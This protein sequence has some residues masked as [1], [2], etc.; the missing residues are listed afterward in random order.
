MRKLIYLLLLTFITISTTKAQR[1][2]DLKTTLITPANATH[3]A[4]GQMFNIRI[5]IKNLSA[6]AIEQNDSIAVY[7]LHDNDTIPVL[8]GGNSSQYEAY[9][10]NL[11]KQ[12]DSVIV[13]KTGSFNVTT[14]DDT[15]NLCL[16]AVPLSGNASS[17]L[18][19]LHPADNIACAIMYSAGQPNTGVAVNTGVLSG[20]RVAP[21]PA[22]Q[23]VSFS[24]DL[25]QPAAV[26]LMVTDVTGRNVLTPLNKNYG[27]GTQQMI[28]PV[29]HLA[30]GVY[31]YR[32]QSGHDIKSGKLL[33]H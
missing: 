13:S 8:I 25:K 22:Y 17:A 7:L 23:D 19:D 31:T 14:V 18:A 12:G 21:N 30:P 10:G 26:S 6:T 15:I 9:T 11:L 16:L 29:Q 4:S 27:I 32:L 1:Q 5:S 24:F 28:V 3:V 20:V 33:I 2:T